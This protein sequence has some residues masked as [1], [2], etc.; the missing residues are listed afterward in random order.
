MFQRRWGGVASM[1][2]RFFN[3]GN[4]LPVQYARHSYKG[5]NGAAVFQ[6]RKCGLEFRQTRSRECFNG[7]AVFQP[8]KYCHLCSREPLVCRFNGA[9]V[10][11]PRKCGNC[12][13]RL[14]RPKS[15][16]GA[17]VFQPRKCSSATALAHPAGALQWGRGFSTAEIGQQ[18]DPV[19]AVRR[20]SMGPRFFNRG[21]TWL[22]SQ[23]CKT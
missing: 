13:W 15:F 16:N 2:P 21:N 3:R 11:Q 6:P 12:D 14:W 9:A 4:L 1:G 7:A 5:F 8:R 23:G 18:V 20:A 17:A 19:A 22:V 10:F